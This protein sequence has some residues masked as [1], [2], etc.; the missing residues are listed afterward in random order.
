MPPYVVYG[1]AA[2]ALGMLTSS[3]RKRVGVAVKYGALA[4][5]AAAF[6]PSFGVR[7]PALPGMR[8][9]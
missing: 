4:A 3:K 9:A 1:L 8:S 5:A 2:A 6:L 7:L